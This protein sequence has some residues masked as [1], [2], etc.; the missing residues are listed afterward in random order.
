[1]NR[2][3]FIKGAVIM[4]AAAYFS[5]TIAFGAEN[6]RWWQKNPVYQIY[7]KS[8]LDTNGSGTGDLQ[9]IIKK[10]DYIKSLGAGAIW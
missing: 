8:F 10:L 6:L 3:E 7:P 1:M 2:R 4:G 9:G 5:P